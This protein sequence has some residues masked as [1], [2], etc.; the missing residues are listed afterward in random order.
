MRSRSTH[1]RSSGGAAVWLPVLLSAV[2][3]LSPFPGALPVLGAQT[4]SSE[5]ST[6]RSPSR[7]R[8]A[9]L[10]GEVLVTWR[11]AAGYEGAYRIWR[12]ASAFEAGAFEES[13]DLFLA[14]TV[15]SGIESLTDRPAVPGAYYYAVTTDIETPYLIEQRNYL[16][17]PVRVVMTAEQAEEP[18]RVRSLSVETHNSEVILRFEASRHGRRLSAYASTEA[19]ES[20][21]DLQ[22]AVRLAVFD[23]DQREYRDYPVPGIPTYYAVLDAEQVIIGEGALVPGQNATVQPVR[24][25][26]GSVLRGTGAPQVGARREAP[27]PLLRM[28]W[29]PATGAYALDLSTAPEELDSETQA[30]L[31]AI[32]AHHGAPERMPPVPTILPGDRDAPGTG[33]R[34]SLTTVLNGPF[35][36][37]EWAEAEMQ[38]SNLLTVASSSMYRA[39]VQFY[40]GQCLYFLGRFNEAAL[41]FVDARDQLFA[42]SQQWLDAALRAGDASR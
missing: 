6:V 29:L 1:D 7:V 18:A 40:R 14:G 12:S 17:R 30:A 21:E 26:L 35:S 39:R 19:I 31:D 28:P 20:S 8:A 16:P 2:L 27:I 25:A 3:I 23:S 9:E 22:R 15:S 33:L 5:A 13:S 24:I 36:R 38:L 4:A 34:S 10:D 42:E 11:D 41:A 32:L 37:T